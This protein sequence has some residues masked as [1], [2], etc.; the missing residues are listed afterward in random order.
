MKP[1][2]IR[3]P[4]SLWHTLAEEA[5]EHGMSTAAY[6]REIL[7]NRQANTPNTQPDTQPNTMAL[8]ERVNALE[9]AVFDDDTRAVVEDTGPRDATPTP[10]A[11]ET[12]PQ[13]TEP[14]DMDAFRAELGEWL[15]DNG[16]QTEHGRR[17]VLRCVDELQARG[18]LT[19][20]TLTDILEDEIGENYSRRKSMWESV[21][22]WLEET[23]GVHKTDNYSEWAF[24]GVDDARAEIEAGI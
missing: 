5:D 19:S 7:R 1:R 2:P 12:P 9:T 18:P 20:E 16:P 24:A 14:G 15:A 17:G 8:A 23:P 13:D 10:D 22:R 3:M 6:V 11:A 4:D 21:K